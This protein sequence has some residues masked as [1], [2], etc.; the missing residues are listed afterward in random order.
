MT[1]ISWTWSMPTERT[2]RRGGVTSRMFQNPS[3]H[4]FSPRIGFA[5]DVFGNGSMAIRGGAGIYYDIGNWGSPMLEEACCQSPTAYQVT[6]SNP[7]SGSGVNPSGTGGVVLGAAV[8]CP[9][10][11]EGWARQALMACFMV[12]AAFPLILISITLKQIL[13]GRQPAPRNV[14]YFL[15]QPSM[16]Q[17]NLTV[18]KQLPWSM[19]LSVSYAGSRGYHLPVNLEANFTVPLGT[20]STGMPYYCYNSV[21]RGPDGVNA[22]LINGVADPHNDPTCANATKLGN[23]GLPTDPTTFLFRVNRTIAS[24]NQYTDRGQSWYD[25]LQVNFTK[26]VSHGLSFTEALT[27]QKML[28]NGQ[29]QQ[30]GESNSIR[31][32]EIL[33]PSVDKG[34]SG[35]DAA[36]NSRFNVIY[37]AP[38]FK[39][40]RFYVL[41]LNGW[42][43]SSI[44]SIQ[45]GYA[46]EPTLS[47]AFTANAADTNRPDIGPNYDPKKVILGKVDQ[48]FDPTMF[49]IPVVGTHGNLGRNTLRS[50]G[51]RNFDFSMVKDTRIKRLGEAGNV[52]FRAEIFNILNHPSFALPSV[53]IW[54]PS[55]AGTLTTFGSAS[56]C[57]T[58]VTVKWC[59]DLL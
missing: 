44:V 47:R 58:P 21:H 26:R 10:R 41:P 27:W 59:F 12:G 13:Q 38:S 39:S 34:I 30:P 45:S 5:Y 8:P 22:P 15:K 14:D 32:S 37:R 17:Y 46:F 40:G 43:F 55:G 31:T 19:A 50:P 24:V 57:S 11:Q 29:S 56:S 6:V 48:W 25:A 7:N 9:S 3:L 53:A 4:A 23:N 16:I 20:L 33:V 35:Y 2:A 1:G 49:S 54:S 51:L 28:D 36:L 52:E 18:D 42:R